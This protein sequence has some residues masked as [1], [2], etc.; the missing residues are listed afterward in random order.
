M[1]WIFI[2]TLFAVLVALSIGSDEP[3]ERS[4]HLP[5]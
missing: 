1:S 2:I 5:G 3:D 4:L